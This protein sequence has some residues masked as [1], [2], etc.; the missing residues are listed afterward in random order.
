MQNERIK[1]TRREIQMKRSTILLTALGVLLYL[2]A[3][4]L[5]AQTHHGGG[6]THGPTTTS[7]GNKDAPGGGKSTE[8]S[9]ATQLGRFFNDTD[10]KL[11]TRISA[12]AVKDGTTISALQGMNFKSLG[13]MISA[14]HVYNNLGLSKT[15]SFADFVTYDKANSLGAAIKHFDPTAD[16]KTETKNA[17][18]QAN[19]D[20][21]ESES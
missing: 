16:P 2:G 7:H 12:L 11:F 21:K 3:V 6:G 19:Q 15:V 14:L 20:I 18:K 13:Q 9:S 10:S 8:T 4:P 5:F 17:R 1:L